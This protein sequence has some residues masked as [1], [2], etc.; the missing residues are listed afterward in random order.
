VGSWNAVHDLLPKDPEGNAVQGSALLLD[1]QDNYV[2]SRGKLVALIGVSGLVVV[3][4]PGALLVVPREQAQ[5]VGEA[6][7]VLEKAGRRDLL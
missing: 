5:R 3:D 4:T 6:V 1:S 7:K 2:D